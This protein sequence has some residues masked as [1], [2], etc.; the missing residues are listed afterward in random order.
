MTRTGLSS[1]T[2]FNSIPFAIRKSLQWAHDKFSQSTSSFSFPPKG[3]RGPSILATNLMKS[4]FGKG[5]IREAR[6]LFDELPDKDVI[7]W[8]AMIAGYTSCNYNTHAW[9]TFCEMVKNGTDPNEY[10]L[11]NVLK[12]CKGMKYL[13]CGA[14]VHGLAI[15]RGMVGSLY[16]ENALMDMYATCCVTMDNACMIFGDIEEKTAVSWTTFITGYTHRGD[17]YGGLQIFRQMLLEEAELNVYCFSIAVRACS[18]IGSLTIGKQLHASVTKHGFGCN[19]P[20]MN[21]I[22][23]MYCRCGYFSDVNQY[24]QEMTEKDLITWN[25]VIAGYER[26]DS[27]ESLRIFSKMESEGLSPNCFTFTSVTAACANLAALSCGQQVHG[28]ILCGGLDGNLALANALI[29]M[30]AKCGSIEDSHK[31]FSEMI[32]RDLLSWTSMMIGYGAHG[33]GIE[34]VN[35]FE[36]MVKSDIKPDHIVFVAILN[37][38]S[39]AGL[40]DE[41]LKYLKLMMSYYNIR[42]D[43]EIYG[44]VVDLLGRAGRVQEAYQLIENM[45][46]KPDESIWGALLGACKEHKLTYLGKMAALRVLDLRPNMGETYVVLSNIYAAEGKWGEFAKT[47]KLMRVMGNKKEVGRSWIEVRNQIYSF[48]VGDKMGSHV[49]CVYAVLGLLIRHMK[50]V[51]YVPDLDCWMHD[52]EDGT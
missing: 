48:V 16:V 52:L 22:L 43:R 50:E 33:Y 30:Y 40:V 23:D 19:L 8:T 44:C 20:I 34:A 12:A 42:P 21:S 37:A 45:P 14:L 25:T 15:K 10:T 3:S 47:R 41:G 28:G 31:I 2:T 7:T 29:D 26:L 36:K 9:S 13:A 24:F 49:K 18:S 39:H 11:S 32:E 38:C 51:G 4:Y 17:G 27:S 35:L 6:I 46:F 1:T 5:L